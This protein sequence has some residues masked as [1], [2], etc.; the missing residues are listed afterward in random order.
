LLH[1]RILMTVLVLAA[2][3]G[4]PLFSQRPVSSSSRLIGTWGLVEQLGQCSLH[5]VVVFTEREGRLEGTYRCMGRTTSLLDVRV[6]AGQVSFRRLVGRELFEFG[7]R[8]DG[9]RLVGT[10]T[11]SFGDLRARA[12]RSVKKHVF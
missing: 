8:I 6:A 2:F 7:G 5:A 1:T 12:H 11:T 9:D 3:G 10:T 4:A